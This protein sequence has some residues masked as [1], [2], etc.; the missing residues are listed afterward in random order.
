MTEGKSGTVPM[1]RKVI[2]IGLDSATFDVIDLL[3]E[4]GYLPNLRSIKENP[5][6]GR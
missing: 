6:L 4:R 1:D 3:I 2:I 5:N